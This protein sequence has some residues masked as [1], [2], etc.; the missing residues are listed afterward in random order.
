MAPVPPSPSGRRSRPRVLQRAG[1][2]RRRRARVR[3]AGQCGDRSPSRAV[4]QRRRPR[5]LRVRLHR[6]GPRIHVVAEQPRQPA[7]AVAKR[8]RQRSRPARPC[9]SATRTAA[10]SGRRR[11]CP[12]AARIRTRCVTG[13][14]IRSTST[15]AR[16]WPPSSCSSCRR[17]NRSRSSGS[18]IRNTSPRRRHC[19]VTLYAEWVLGENR[20]R[21]AHPRR[22]RHRAGHGRGPRAQRVSARSFRSASPSS[23]CRPA[24]RATRHRRSDGVH[25]TQR[26]ARGGR[27]RSDASGCRT[28]PGPAL[29]PC[30]AVRVE[31]DLE[32]G[33]E[34]VVIGL[35]GDAVD[36]AQVR[37][38]VERYRDLGARRRGARA[39][40]GRSGTA[41]SERWPC[42]RPIGRWTSC[43]TA[44]CSIRRWRAASGGDRRSISPAAPSDSAISCRTRWRC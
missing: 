6:V 39:P 30:G 21:T 41:C 12:P 16:S 33:E 32:P 29:D 27:P 28:G 1:R 31:V 5:A 40:C 22:H 42:A 26:I 13:T 10:R 37:A 23:I 18:R 8:S 3:H 4:D 19:S 2:V 14:A 43:S 15:S 9:S 20:S 35:L 17:T 38:L 11:R 7:H 34:Q 25:R 36:A 24:S 44:G